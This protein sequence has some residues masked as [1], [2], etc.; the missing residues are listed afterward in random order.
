LSARFA[1]L[2]NRLFTAIHIS[3][4]DQYMFGCKLLNVRVDHS[5]RQV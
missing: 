1:Y 3:A 5:W 4:Y 2:G